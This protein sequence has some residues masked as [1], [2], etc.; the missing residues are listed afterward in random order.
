MKS[1]GGHS[2]ETWVDGTQRI[3]GGLIKGTKMGDGERGRALCRRSDWND[4]T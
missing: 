4:R 1:G 2:G 3:V